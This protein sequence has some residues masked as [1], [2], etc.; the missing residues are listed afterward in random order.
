MSV[1]HPYALCKSKQDAVALGLLVFTLPHTRC[2]ERA[3]EG[4]GHT[5]ALL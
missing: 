3:L 4:V 2:R 1:L 5:P